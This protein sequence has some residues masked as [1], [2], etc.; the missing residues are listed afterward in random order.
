MLA[1]RKDTKAEEANP[2]A[3]S[4]RR[5]PKKTVVVVHDDGE[6][7][8]LV[9]YADMMTLLF[10][11][12]VMLSAF[13]TPDTKKLEKLKQATAEQMGGTYQKPFEEL[14]SSI[15]DVLKQINLSKEVI[16]NETEEG[17]TI[18]SKGTLFFD[19]GSAEMRDQALRM[20]E[21]LSGVLVKQAQGFRIVVE[22]HTDDV[23]M[24]SQN[25]PSNWELSSA[26]ASM[27]VRLLESKGFRRE[28]LRPL[29]LAD[30]EPV[31]PNRSTAGEPIESNRAENRR[32][33]IRLQK[34]IYS[35]SEPEKARRA[36]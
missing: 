20:M 25:Y 29:G 27:V 30:T 2:K 16:V 22:G 17:V 7:N 24:K 1:A 18:T 31:L 36:Q 11:F 8:W 5:R 4:F 15:K 34:N 9:S 10:G 35:K 32:I 21:G 3:A 28:F 19:S 12:F 33:V 14:S 26:R 6:S 23:P 13:S